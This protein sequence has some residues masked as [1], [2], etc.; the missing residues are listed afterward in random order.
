MPGMMR[1]P[2]AGDRPV[3]F[4]VASSTVTVVDSPDSPAPAGFVRFT[5]EHDGPVSSALTGDADG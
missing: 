2:V 5:F 1:Y 4:T 3:W